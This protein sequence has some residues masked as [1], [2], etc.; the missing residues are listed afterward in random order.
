[1]SVLRVLAKPGGV[2]VVPAGA[3]TSLGGHSGRR[4]ELVP[5][6]FARLSAGI[7][8]TD[9]LVADIESALAAL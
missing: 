1:M 4:G 2:L 3:T 6:G 7:G 9:D 8:D 5:D